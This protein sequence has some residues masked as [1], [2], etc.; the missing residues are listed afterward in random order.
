ML[1]YSAEYYLFCNEGDMKICVSGRTRASPVVAG[2]R[3]YYLLHIP[4]M[5]R[6]IQNFFPV[7][8]FNTITR[9]REA[10]RDT[11]YRGEMRRDRS[12]ASSRESFS[13]ALLMPCAKAAG[14]FSSYGSVTR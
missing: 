2:A 8:G 9:D 11:L 13:M 7:T 10:A 4:F 14:P 6:N 1:N 3:I 12:C 5:V